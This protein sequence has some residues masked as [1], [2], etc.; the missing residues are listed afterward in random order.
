VA[1]RDRRK[2]SVNVKSNCKDN[3][4]LEQVY[5]S[6]RRLPKDRELISNRNGKQSVLLIH[7]FY[8]DLLSYL[9]DEVTVYSQRLQLFSMTS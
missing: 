1:L 9:I 4:R 5:A 2:G 7:V 8:F 3:A 6:Q